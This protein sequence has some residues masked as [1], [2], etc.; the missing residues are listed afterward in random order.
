MAGELE[1]EVELEDAAELLQFDDQTL[2]E[3][4]LLPMNEQ[5][6]WFL[7]MKPISDKDTMKLLKLQVSEYI[8]FV[9]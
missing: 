4:E 5:R 9:D 2:M 8:N 1:L 3:A 7:E 6:M